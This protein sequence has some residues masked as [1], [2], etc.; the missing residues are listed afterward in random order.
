[1]STPGFVTCRLRMPNQERHFEHIRANAAYAHSMATYGSA[2]G[3]TVAIC[4][5]GPS[6]ADTYR[7]IAADDVW[8]CNS[9]LPWLVNRGARV[10]HG[11]AIDQGEDMLEDWAIT[12]DV[13]YLVASTVHPSLP[14]HL[15]SHGRDLRW[16]HNIVADAE[17]QGEEM[18]LYDTLY[19]T[20]LR[21]NYGLNSVPRA[22]CLA[23]GMGYDR[24]LVYGGDCAAKPDAPTMPELY[25]DEYR[26]WTKSVVMYC[27]GRS[28]HET[29]GPEEPLMESAPTFDPSRRWHT[30]PDM[31]ISATHLVQLAHSYA[32]RIAFAGDTLV[33]HLAQ[34]SPD[35]LQAMPGLTAEGHVVGIGNHA[36]LQPA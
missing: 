3:R 21:A 23:L 14:K 8:A 7:D 33:S 35:F 15:I 13:E 12:F 11:F 9:A 30:R 2:E 18:A 17:H 10:T 26:E 34:Q 31:V 29:F 6:L 1:M 28:A 27:D 20:S 16:F 22:V 4:G 36:S 32:G 19:P 5:A 25:T 24:I